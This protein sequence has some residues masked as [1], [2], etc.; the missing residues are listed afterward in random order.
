[1]PRAF[2][3]Q[4]AGAP[5]LLGKMTTLIVNYFHTDRLH[6]ATVKKAHPFNF[7][8]EKKSVGELYIYPIDKP[9]FLSIFSHIMNIRNMSL[10]AWQRLCS[11]KFNR[12]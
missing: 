4:R 1:M 3:F 8:G 2:G 12:F 5:L 6:K 10:I 11:V 9:V 7:D